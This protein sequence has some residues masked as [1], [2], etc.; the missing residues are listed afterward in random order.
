MLLCIKYTQAQTKT[1]TLK[2]FAQ[3]AKNDSVSNATIQ[4]FLLPD[5]VLTASQVYHK[6]GNNFPVT[7]FAKYLV[8]VSCVG[9][10]TSSKTINITDKPVATTYILKRSTSNL[11][12]VT[13]ISTKKPLIKQEDDKTVVDAMKKRVI[14]IENGKVVR[15]EVKGVYGYEN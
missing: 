10:A 11:Q 4:L 9:F 8:T 3:A 2:I 1:T 6:N 5:T 13:V 12:N 14:A 15:D 7:Q